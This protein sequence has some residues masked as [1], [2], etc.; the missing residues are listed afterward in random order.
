[1]SYIKNHTEIEH[2]RRSCRVAAEIMQEMVAFVKPGIKTIDIDHLAEKLTS[3]H[4]VTPSFQGYLN[5]PSA[6]C[7]SVNNHVVHGLPGEQVLEE[8][9]IVGIDFG[10]KYRGYFSD[11]ARTVPVGTVDV[12]AKQL[13]EV[14]KT[15]L[16]KAIEQIRPGNRTGDIGHAVQSYVEDQGLNVVRELVGHGVGTAVHEPPSVPNYGKP[17]RGEQLV[18]GMV[19][20]VEPMVNEKSAGVQLMDDGWTFKTK[21]EGRSAHFEDTILVTERGHEVLTNF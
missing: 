8:G 19:L 16:K 2:I 5:Y 4:D 14:T 17:A 21:D 1:M 10:V 7:I 20:A 12:K 13:I 3:K 11:L 6:T 18:A 9:D 15:S